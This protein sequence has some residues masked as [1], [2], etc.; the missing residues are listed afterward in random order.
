MT[1]YHR[2]VWSINEKM[3]AI[4]TKKKALKS[5]GLPAIR[6]YNKN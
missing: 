1:V 3:C 6:L 5:G 4:N 2:A